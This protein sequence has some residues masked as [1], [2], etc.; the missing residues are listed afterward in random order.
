MPHRP[1]SHCFS[2][3]PNQGLPVPV[4][5]PL[6]HPRALYRVLHLGPAPLTPFAGRVRSRSG[7]A[8]IPGPRTGSVPI[9]PHS[10]STLNRVFPHRVHSYPPPFRLYPEGVSHT[11][12]FIWGSP[13][14]PLAGRVPTHSGSTL[15][16]VSPYRV[17]PHPPP[18]GF[19][20]NRGF[21]RRVRSH[22][23]PFR[24]HPEGLSRT[25]PFVWVPQCTPTPTPPLV[26][27][28]SAS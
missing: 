17:C 1:S 6:Y 3:L 26:S 15:K 11:G 27:S 8:I 23:S 18:T 12:P 21:P 2:L 13:L 7:S 25:G 10:G 16:M 28:P 5:V 4:Q 20:L 24:P 19:T 14:T 22:S 9:R